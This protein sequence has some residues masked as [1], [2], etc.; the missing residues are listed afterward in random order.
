PVDWVPIDVNN[1]HECL[2]VEAF[3]QAFDPLTDPMHPVADRHVGQKNEQLIKLQPGQQFHFQLN[4]H[5]FTPVEQQV[6]IEIR[7]G[8]IPR[9]FAGR[10]RSPTVRRTEFLDPARTIPLGIEIAA[11]PTRV[12]PPIKTPRAALLETTA[13]PAYARGINCLAPPEASTTQLFRAG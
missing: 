6:A 8:V 4:A 2:V 5:N 7:R 13:A 1:G 9:G 11:R 10:F 12:T 3:I